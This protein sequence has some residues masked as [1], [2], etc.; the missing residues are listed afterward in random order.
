MSSRTETLL[1]SISKNSR[2][3]E[4]GPSFN[5]IAPKSQGWN[6]ASIDHLD[7]EG[8]ASKYEA[9]PGVDVSRIEPVD[10]VWTRGLLSDAVPSEQHGSFD[11]F[12][13]SHVIEHTPDLIAFLDAAQTLLKEDGVVVLAIPDK[14]YCFDYF[15][16]PTTT[17]QVLEAHA[18]HRQRHSG[19]RGFDH[20]AYAVTNGGE[21]SWGQ[22]PSQGIRLIHA[23][24]QAAQIYAWLESSADYHDLHAWHF[25]P[26]SF[27][28]LLLELGALGETDWRIERITPTRG[29]EFFAWLRRGAGTR[30]G[31]MPAEDLQSRRVALLKNILLE[32]QAQIDWLLASEPQLTT[33]PAGVSIWATPLM[34]E[35]ATSALQ[36]SQDEIWDL[37]NRLADS[38]VRYS[39]AMRRVSAFET[40][41]SWRATAPLRSLGAWLQRPRAARI[42]PAKQ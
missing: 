7:R 23:L 13:A 15:Q 34:Y 18:R 38:E 1:G 8:L 27:E 30:F 37:R 32:T 3:I 36:K 35:A 20:F 17:G 21:E 22:R 14:R 9:H 25:V 4:I 33:E 41:T 28:L 29:C 26:P 40:S 24:D 5:P 11:V 19:E 6:S 10:F 42:G 2:I 31:S 39:A 16:P 12:L